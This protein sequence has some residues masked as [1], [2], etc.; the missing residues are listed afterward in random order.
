[1]P[2][3]ILISLFI[4]FFSAHSFSQ[5]QYVQQDDDFLLIRY[6]SL[7]K[8]KYAKKRFDGKIEAGFL[9]YQL[10]TIQV[11]PTP[12]WKGYNLNEE[13][14]G[15]NLNGIYGIN[16][17]DFF[18]GVGLGYLYFEGIHGGAIF[19]DL[20]YVPTIRKSQ[21][22][23][24]LNLKIGFNHIWNQYEHGKTSALEEIGVG[25]YY[26]FDWRKNEGLFLQ[27]GVLMTQQ[28]LL[29]PIRLGFRF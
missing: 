10:T 25:I 23:P 14:N 2:R 17:N 6:T 28:A 12:G 13:Q 11:D 1:M 4:I 16:L 9:K 18:A 27:T 22:S 21:I 26:R 3:Q 7:K 5:M 15:I 29:I 19:T 8:N 24:L 20:M